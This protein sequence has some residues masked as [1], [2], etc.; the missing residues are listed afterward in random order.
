M[1]S[2]ITLEPISSMV[3]SR[4]F[5]RCNIS[6]GAQT[7][8]PIKVKRIQGNI[9]HLLKYSMQLS[10]HFYTFNLNTTYKKC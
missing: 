1:N 5:R 2:Y 3:Y 10:L 7:E 6:L 9:I 8:S 4:G